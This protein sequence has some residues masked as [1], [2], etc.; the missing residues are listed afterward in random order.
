LAGS[1]DLI[2]IR[3]RGNYRRPFTVVDQVE[4][5]AEKETADKIAVINAQIDGFNQEL[6]KLT[7]SANGE[8]DQAVV[9]STIVQK[10]RELEGKIYQAQKQLR[11]VQAKRR[12]KIEELG[13][14]LKTANMATV[15]G[16]VMLI[17][18]VLGVWRGVRRRHYIS[19]K[20]DA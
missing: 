18:L 3:S 16:V 7:S 9:G 12:E 19:H 4:Q 11:A 20:S 6:Q 5:D 15:P 10:K 13:S 1:G 17:A 2:S 8:D 14:T